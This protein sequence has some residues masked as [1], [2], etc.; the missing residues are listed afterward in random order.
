MLLLWDRMMSELRVTV[1]SGQSQWS[2]AGQ[3]DRI[4]NSPI[5]TV[6]MR[7]SSLELYFEC[8]LTKCGFVSTFY[9]YFDV[10]VFLILEPKQ[11]HDYDCFAVATKFTVFCFCPSSYS[12]TRQPETVFVSRTVSMS[13]SSRCTVGVA[14]KNNGVST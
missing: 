1:I 11:C 4:L 9:C 3:P 2:T 12:D 8:T 5:D 6:L 13:I 14:L 7:F 10:N